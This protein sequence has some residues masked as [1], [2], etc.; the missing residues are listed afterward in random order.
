MLKAQGKTDEALKLL[1]KAGEKLATLKET[2]AAIKYL[3]GQVIELLEL[4]D[5]KKAKDLGTKLMSSDAVKK[6][7]E[8]ANV[9]GAGN[10]KISA[11]LQKRIQEMMDKQKQ[12]Q[13]LPMPPGPVAPAPDAPPQDAPAP[14]APSQDAP[15]GN[16]P[17]PAPSGAP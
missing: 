4:I 15:P 5:P 2:P 10:Q 3:G 8:S 14:D 13:P 9:T 11:E 17:A 6:M 1:D 16:A 7:N 12:G